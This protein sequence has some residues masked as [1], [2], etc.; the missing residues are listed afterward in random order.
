MRRGRLV[1]E[2]EAKNATQE[3]VMTHAAVAEI[4]IGA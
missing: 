3:E 1:A 4:G 2:L